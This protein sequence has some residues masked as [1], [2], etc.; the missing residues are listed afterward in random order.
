MSEPFLQWVGLSA[1]VLPD[2]TVNLSVAE[3]H[4]LFSRRSYD[5]YYNNWG[6]HCRFDTGPDHKQEPVR[7]A[8]TVTRCLTLAIAQAVAARSPIM[9]RQLRTV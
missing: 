8:P 1:W 9:V 6:N 5:Y 3:V 4:H 7:V 2:R